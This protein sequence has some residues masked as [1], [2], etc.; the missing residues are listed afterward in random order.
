MIV[1]SNLTA[2]AWDVLQQ[3]GIL[4]AACQHVD[5]DFLPA[6]IWMAEQMERRL[7]VP[8]PSKDMMPIWVWSQWWGGRRKPDL[9]ATG[10][11]PKGTRGVRIECKVSDERVLLSDFEL[12]HFV[13]NYGYLPKTE[14]EEEKFERELTAAGLSLTGCSLR[15]PLSNDEYREKIEKSWERIFDL[16][17]TDPHHAIV[18]R[19][20]DRSI[21]G[22]MWE[23]WL[24]D[25]VDSKDFKAR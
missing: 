19:T 1:W 17:W 21:Q 8:R 12:W 18:T 6:Y 5:S 20:K 23:L 7:A 10:H 14:K 2:E 13:L 3:K 22:T 15:N 9:R 24:D 25:V 4:R 11:L 16:T